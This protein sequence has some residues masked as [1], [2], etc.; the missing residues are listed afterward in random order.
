MGN[1]VGKEQPT[2]SPPKTTTRP[3]PIRSDSR[4]VPG[5][6]ERRRRTTEIRMRLQSIHPNPGPRDKT[7]EGRKRRMERKRAARIRKRESR[8]LQRNEEMAGR[9][10]ENLVV[11]TWNVQGMSL[12]GM[13]K[14]KAK[15]VARMAH[16]QLWD[17]VMLTEISAEGVGVVWLGQDEELVALVHSEKA[18]VL[19]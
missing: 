15:T 2:D 18:A 17:A 10:K 13:W 9:K 7:E 12:R 19:L 8:R 3:G 11:V 16:E 5:Q 6:D 1:G 4:K 14:R